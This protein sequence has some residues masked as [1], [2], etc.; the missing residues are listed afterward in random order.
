MLA[1][2]DGLPWLLLTI[3]PFVFLQ[4]ALHREIQ[5]VLLLL[6]RRIEIALAI[7]SLLFLPGVIVHEVSHFLMAKLLRV[8]TGNFSIVP[9]QL[10]DGRLL[11]GYVETAPTDFLRDALIGAAPLISGGLIVSYIGR[12]R[13]GMLSLW[14]AASSLDG[15]ILLA[16]LG[17][18]YQRPDFW[19]W[20]YLIVTI[21]ST[22]LPS[23]SDRRGWVPVFLA[24][25]L[26]LGVG[27]FVG[28][29]PWML[30]HLAPPIINTIR[31]LAIVIA[32]SGA[33]HLVVL[34]P[35]FLMRYFMSRIFQLEVV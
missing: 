19:L 31:A 7:F 10:D 9:R 8:R 5:A 32:M 15:A 35:T 16:G 14:D 29:G 12:V 20:F 24:L 23:T 17:E 30:Q 25:T 3:L 27:L 18:V 11:L 33:I 26:L 22:M 28:F 4:R 21:S 6:T 1:Q 13:L 2:L 34:F